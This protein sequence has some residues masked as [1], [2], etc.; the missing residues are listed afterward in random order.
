MSE[1]TVSGLVDGFTVPGTRVY[2]VL[3]GMSYVQYYYSMLLYVEMSSCRVSR[4]DL[5]LLADETMLALAGLAEE[6][7]YCPAPER[8]FLYCLSCRTMLFG[9]KKKMPRSRSGRA[10]LCV[11]NR[12]GAAAAQH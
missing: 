2:R 11:G 3:Y 6:C 1:V 8:P 4:V 5:V 12:R 7:Q 10:G 9:L